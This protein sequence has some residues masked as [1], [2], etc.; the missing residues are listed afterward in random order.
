MYHRELQLSSQILG[1]L[2]ILPKRSN[3]RSVRTSGTDGAVTEMRHHSF[4]YISINNG[5]SGSLMSCRGWLS[6]HMSIGGNRFYVVV[7]VVRAGE[8]VGRY[9][10]HP[11]LSLVGFG[12]GLVLRTAALTHFMMCLL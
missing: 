7:F 5:L 9:I 1:V 11:S 3:P 10:S 2:P 12:L 8:S 4:M 6:E